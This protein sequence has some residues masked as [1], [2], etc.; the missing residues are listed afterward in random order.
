[1]GL[2]NRFLVIL[3]YR[4][5]IHHLLSDGDGNRCSFSIYALNLYLSAHQL[6]ETFGEWHWKAALVSR[7]TSVKH[8]AGAFIVFCQLPNLRLTKTDSCILH[9]KFQFNP[10]SL[11]DTVDRNSDIAFFCLSDCIVDAA[12]QNIPQRILIAKQHTWQSVIYLKHI[13]DI[14]LLGDDIHGI[15]NVRHHRL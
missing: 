15:G 14:L 12:Y 13:P 6:E 11:A 5:P 8:L 9:L 3:S 2:L 1:M 10:L 4:Q 7:N